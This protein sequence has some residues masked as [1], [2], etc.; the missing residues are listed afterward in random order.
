MILTI[1]YKLDEAEFLLNCVYLNSEISI[2]NKKIHLTILT[3]DG[4]SW[5]R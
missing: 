2:N 4:E 3:F 1:S 5:F